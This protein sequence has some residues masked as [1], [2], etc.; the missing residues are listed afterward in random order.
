MKKM[1]TLFVKDKNHLATENFLCE[2]VFDEGVT[3]HIKRDG[4]ACAVI[5]GELYKRYNFK[6]CGV[7]APPEGAIQCCDPDEVTGH[8]PHWI[9]CGKVDRWHRRAW[10]TQKPLSDGTYELV[11]PKINGN[12]ENH[13]RHHLLPHKGGE[14]ICLSFCFSYIDFKCFIADLPWE[15]VVF[16][17]P[18]GQMCKLRRKDFGLDWPIDLRDF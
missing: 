16:H 8:W 2:W 12:N 13:K 14:L 7:K 10:E 11:G 5:D 9:K 15:G 18:N 3:T 4:F 1:K 6:R 17:H